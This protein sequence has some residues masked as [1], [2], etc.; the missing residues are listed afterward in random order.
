MALTTPVQL[1]TRAGALIPH[2]VYCSG[3]GK[4]FAIWTAESASGVKFVAQRHDL[5]ATFELPVAPDVV[6]FFDVIEVATDQ[7]MV[8]YSTHETLKYFVYNFATNA[9]VTDVTSIQLGQAPS[10]LPNEVFLYVRGNALKFKIGV[11]GTE[12][13]LLTSPNYAIPA[14][15]S[16]VKAP[17][18]FRYLGAHSPNAEIAL[19]L[20]VKADTVFLHNCREAVSGP[21]Y[22]FLDKSGHGYSLSV[23]SGAVALTGYGLVGLAAISSMITAWNASAAQITVEVKFRP[24]LVA[25]RWIHTGQ[26]GFGVGEDGRV[27]WSYHDGTYEHRLTQERLEGVK[28]G[29]VNY[30]AVRHIWGNKASSA[31]VVNGIEVPT[32]WRS[33]VPYLTG[34]TGSIASIADAGGGYCRA[35]TTAP[36]GLSNGAVVV[37]SGTAYY[38]G[39]YIISNASG[40]LFDFRQVYSG[41][42]GGSWSTVNTDHD[43]AGA[44]YPWFTT[45]STALGLR[46]N[47]VLVE[48]AVS[49]VAAS[50]A[51]LI[52][53]QFGRL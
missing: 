34:T 4:V 33:T 24:G 30:I 25:S 7:A 50:A 40:S 51:D 8:F 10:I 5:T 22:T 6:T 17:Y 28:L 15:D 44:T 9:I 39:A 36:H 53:R 21:P 43:K 52:D 46:Y 37:I 3:L 1:S 48:H 49:N 20:R 32:K 23:A 29:M 38:N 27:W 31:I 16:F 11:A 13:T 47:D 2:G 26:I 35:T 42:E 14:I 45:I 41:T 18:I 12:R 19:P